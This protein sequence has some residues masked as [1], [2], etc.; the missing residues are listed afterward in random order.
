MPEVTKVKKGI[1]PI[2]KFTV[3]IARAS[4]GCVTGGGFCD[5][6]FWLL[7]KQLFSIDDGEMGFTGTVNTSAQTFELKLEGDITGVSEDNNLE[8]SANYELPTEIADELGVS[9]VYLDEDVYMYDSGIGEFGGY[10]VSYY[11]VE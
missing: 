11:T 2:F 10:I 4:Q 7:G 6:D 8:V 1:F 9:H 3:E 5:A